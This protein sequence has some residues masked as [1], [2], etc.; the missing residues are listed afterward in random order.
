MVNKVFSADKLHTINPQ[1]ILSLRK[2]EIDDETGL[3]PWTS[4]LSL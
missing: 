4:L 2:L 1:R 3:W